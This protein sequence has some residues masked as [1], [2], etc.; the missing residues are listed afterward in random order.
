V[1]LLLLLTIDAVEQ[2]P[3]TAPVFIPQVVGVV[4]A[5]KIRRH[6][7]IFVQLAHVAAPQLLISA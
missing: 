1:L 7:K 5:V 2:E 4:I 6:H 3:H